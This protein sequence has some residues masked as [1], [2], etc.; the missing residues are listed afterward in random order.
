VRQESDVDVVVL[1]NEASFPDFSRTLAGERTRIERTLGPAPYTY[2]AFKQAIHQA[3]VE[4]FG[5]QRVERRN[6]CIF[7]KETARRINA[8]VIP[9]WIHYRYGIVGSLES[10]GIAITA[11]DGTIHTS[12]PEQHFRNGEAKNV[13]V[14]RRYKRAVRILKRLRNR[15]SDEGNVVARSVASFAIECALYNGPDRDYL[16]DSHRE[17]MRANLTWL[18]TALGDGT[19]IQQMV[20]VNNIQRLF[21]GTH[22]PGA[23]RGLVE[24]AWREIGL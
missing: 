15:F 6:K 7:V 5:T 11:D 10:T 19:S 9:A 14:L 20:E 22:D 1:S 16:F 13:L 21:R 23:L 8:D 2:E 24:H 17:R 18:Y 4:A 12:F 3:L